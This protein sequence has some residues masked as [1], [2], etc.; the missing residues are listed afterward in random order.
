VA[1][2]NC[3]DESN[4]AFCGG[5]GVQGFPT[6]KIVK[7]SKTAGKP[8]VEDYQG[9]R[10][11]TGIVDAV[12][13]AIPNH[14]KRI[15]D[16]GLN[17]WLASNNDTTKAILFSEKG[18]TGAL[19]K[20]LATEFLNSVEF[21][22]IRNKEKAANEMFGI[23]RYPTLIILPGGIKEP[24]HFDG[25]FS[26]DAMKEFL[27]Q[28]VSPTSESPTM[29][30][31]AVAKDSE[32]KKDEEPAKS[33]SDSSTFS[34]ASASHAASEASDDVID[35]T[36]IVLEDPKPTES[37]DPIAVSEDAPKPVIVLDLPPPIS[38]ITEEKDLQT[39]CLGEKTPICILA[40]LPMT[41]EDES[42]L[43]PDAYA[44]LE[45]LAE[46]AD[47]H[48]RR[49]RK[50]FPFYSVPARNSGSATLRDVL[51]L[52]GDDQLELVVINSRR[53]WWRKYQ[54]E[55]YD[56]QSVEDWVDNIRYGEGERRKLPEG[57]VIGASEEKENMPEGELKPGESTEKPAA[58]KHEEL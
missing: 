21:A 37:P 25:A 24:V 7:P 39:Q 20:V 13:A 30:Q 6:L 22:Q 51:K 50:L 15:A 43:P 40:L 1:A 47:K 3:D 35:A 54:G 42:L 17:D 33:A 9:A 16:K 11:A 56:R 55:Q 27:N 53:G 38:T 2:I 19:I 10:T 58:P 32:K 8:I 41:A 45:S 4:K 14:V 28:Y 12:K 31:K 34:K 44:A 52:R 48:V 18:T 5:M 49:G 46:I 29:E 36:T 26:K 23:A 57:L